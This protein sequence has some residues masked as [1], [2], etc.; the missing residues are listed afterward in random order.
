MHAHWYH[1]PAVITPKEARR[2]I[3]HA[4]R[5]YQPQ[6]ATVG[7]GAVG[8]T[9]RDLRR[10]TVRWLDYA[11]LNLF[12]LFRRLEKFALIANR[13]AFGYDLQPGFTEVQF[14]E[15]HAESGDHYGWHEDS[16][17]KMKR[18]MERKLT[19]VMQL[20][21]PGDYEGGRLELD[22]DP[23]SEGLHRQPGDTLFFRSALRHRATAVTRGVRYSLVSWIHGPLR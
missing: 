22:A 9:D 21:D 19:L 10:S 20:S 4:L 12:W 14:T 1:C 16:S 5:H 3:K 17:P 7:H 18:P 11:D 13:D 8:R 15:Y 23:V 2:L 6:A